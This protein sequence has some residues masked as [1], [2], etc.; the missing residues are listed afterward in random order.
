MPAFV[1]LAGLV[2]SGDGRKVVL[3]ELLN[4]VVLVPGQEPQDVAR[5]DQ[6][7]GARVQG[8]ARARQHV[9]LPGVLE[10]RGRRGQSQEDDPD[11][12]RQKHQ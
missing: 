11:D 5:Q 3:V 2:D 10:S 12:Y 7:P 9:R 1:G 8:L 6:G 4:G